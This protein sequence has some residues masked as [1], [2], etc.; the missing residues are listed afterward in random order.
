MEAKSVVYCVDELHHR[1]GSNVRVNVMRACSQLNIVFCYEKDS[2]NQLEFPSANLDPTF[3]EGCEQ[4]M[5]NVAF[6]CKTCEAMPNRVGKEEV[7]ICRS[8]ALSCHHWHK[9][10]TKNFDRH[11]DRYKNTECECKTKHPICL[12]KNKKIDIVTKLSCHSITQVQLDSTMKITNF[13]LVC[14]KY[15]F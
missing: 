3:I 9:K 5:K 1:N 11:W 2:W 12:F 8:C 6:K 4:V 15:G 10:Q 7:W 14:W 13:H